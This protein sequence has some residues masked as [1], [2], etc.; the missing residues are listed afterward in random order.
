MQSWNIGEKGES[1]E[2]CG[3]KGR[4]RRLSEG[5]KEQ[6]RLP[7]IKQPESAFGRVLLYF[8]LS[9]KVANHIDATM[10]LS[11]LN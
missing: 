8:F 5:R 4:L 9:T 3:L 11:I 1:A 6:G 10:M 2:S 7:F